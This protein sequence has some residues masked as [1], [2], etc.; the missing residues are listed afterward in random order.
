MRSVIGEGS[1]KSKSLPRGEERY[2]IKRGELGSSVLGTDSVHRRRKKEGTKRKHGGVW[3]PRKAKG[4]TSR[5]SRST[6]L[7]VTRN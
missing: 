2:L 5:T 7:P 3:L 6:S 1:K 4:R